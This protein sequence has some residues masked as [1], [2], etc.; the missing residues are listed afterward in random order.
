MTLGPTW[1]AIE[2]LHIDFDLTTK[3]LIACRPTTE[4]LT[5]CGLSDRAGPQST[6]KV[7]K[8]SMNFDWHEQS[9]DPS[10]ASHSYRWQFSSSKDMFAYMAQQC[11]SEAGLSADDT[12]K[13]AFPCKDYEVGKE[14]SN[15]RSMRSK[16]RHKPQCR[17]AQGPICWDIIGSWWSSNPAP[18]LAW[19]FFLSF[20]L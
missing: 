9:P 19:S 18:T 20:G 4:Y 10:S 11:P 1:K 2:H 6:T 8:S 7:R 5:W 15:M 13:S 12:K 14:S 17:A 16:V 3:D